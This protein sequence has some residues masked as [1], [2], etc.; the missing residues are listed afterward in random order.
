MPEELFRPVRLREAGLP[1]CRRPG[2]DPE[3]HGVPPQQGGAD[4]RLGRDRR[5][6]IQGDRVDRVLPAVRQVPNGGLRP[7]PTPTP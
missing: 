7:T 4:G 3:G 1:V 6:R 2:R 5:G